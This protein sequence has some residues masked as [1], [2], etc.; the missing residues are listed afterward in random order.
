VGLNDDQEKLRQAE[1]WLLTKPAT[2]D[3]W[4]AAWEHVS[5]ILT[6]TGQ[7]ELRDQAQ[8][9]ADKVLSE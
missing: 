7:P 1:V 8:K 6:Y 2:S 5:W 9:I 4:L 3:Q